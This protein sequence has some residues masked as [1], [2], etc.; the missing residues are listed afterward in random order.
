MRIRRK[1]RGKKYK[2]GGYIPKYQT[3][4]TAECGPGFTK[5]ASGNCVPM[6]P[7]PV[8]SSLEG[9]PNNNQFGF[10]LFGTN[11]IPNPGVN[12]DAQLKKIE[13]GADMMNLEN[14]TAE[15][16]A[17]ST[18]LE[19]QNKAD[20][21]NKAATFDTFLQEQYENDLNQDLGTPENFGNPIQNRQEDPFF[22]PYAG[23][24]I[25]T[26][27]N[28][29]GQSIGPDGDAGTAVASGAKLV[30]GLGRNIAGGIG[31]AKRNSEA[32][33]E[34][35]E[36]R[37]ESLIG[38]PT[39]LGEDGGVIKADLE[40]LFNKVQFPK[41]E[42]GGE[43]NIDLL[44]GSYATGT[45][46][47]DENVELEDG[48]YLQEPEG[49]P[50]KVEGKTHEEGGEKM[51]LKGDTEVL[52]DNLK[53]NKTQVKAIAAQYDLK[54]S[55]KD[56]YAKVLDKYNK[57]IGLTPLIEEEEEVIKEI[58]K[59]KENAAEKE[60]DESTFNIN[61]EFLSSK[62]KDIT[63]KKQALEETSSKVF[64]EIF[65]MQEDSKPEKDKEIQTEFSIGGRVYSKDQI[66]SIA[67]EFDVEENKALEIIK[68]MEDG[69][70]T[71]PEKGR[72]VTKEEAE[73]KVASGEWEM[74]REGRYIKKGEPGKEFTLTESVSSE[75]RLD[76]YKKAW[77]EVGRVDKDMY[78]TFDSFVNAAEEYWKNNPRLTDDTKEVTT[79]KKTP[80][81]P[82]ELFFT[83]LEG[84]KGVKA[85]GIQSLPDVKI[86]VDL[87]A[88]QAELQRKMDLNTEIPSDEVVVDKDNLID[89]GKS[90]G[91]FNALLLPENMPL[92]PQGLQMPLK[93]NRRYGRMDRVAL[94]PDARLAELERG[95]DAAMAQLE[96]LP[97]GQK[98]AS[99]MQLQANK[100]AQAD[101]IVAATEQEEN[102][103]NLNIDKFNVR[104]GDRQEDADAIDALDFERRAFGALA[105][106]E[107][108]FR[109][110]FNTVQER[111]IQ[112]F[113]TINSVNLLNQASE[114]FSFGNE[115]VEFTGGAYTNAEDSV[116]KSRFSR[117]VGVSNSSKTKEA[118]RGGRIR[119]KKKY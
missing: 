17:F 5:D 119:R 57:E 50:K 6:G 70:S 45:N 73:K 93:V 22:N 8:D 25:P 10:S 14:E 88:M 42:D 52:S 43:F 4:G 58:K 86:D 61:L 79:T 81:T 60:A 62:L 91:K 63:D 9:A 110:F 108:D 38:K 84:V 106:T 13:E 15:L 92:P 41:M 21:A 74:I 64:G 71:D 112:N 30:L 33:K 69:G 27:A 67:K 23:V 90:R 100:Q 24:D 117:A 66:V 49:T 118:R 99:I 77:D 46:N 36:K 82:D 98:E 65:K 97:S 35:R 76:S 111:N 55:T 47:G 107:D 113:N 54:V 78:P 102:A 114:N 29:F 19:A 18:Q 7:V 2:A 83:E 3:G 32:M 94:S 101:K 40:A 116:N 75:T 1:L 20:D 95:V 39:A 37:R 72:K 11:T 87:E 85:Y 16:N 80:G 26:A 51:N 31:M 96:K 53:L 59:Q 115:G 34:L 44:T 109:R 48:E 105:N 68:S 89:D 104:Q 12:Y 103:T 56:T 28:I